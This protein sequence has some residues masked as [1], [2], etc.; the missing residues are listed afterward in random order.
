LFLWDDAFKFEAIAG[1]ANTL[2][3]R[4]SMAPNMYL[5]LDQLQFSSETD[6]I[7]IG[8]PSFSET[9]EKRRPGIWVWC[10]FFYDQAEIELPL[11]HT[12]KRRSQYHPA[13][14]IIRVVK[15]VK[16]GYPPTEKNYLSRFTQPEPW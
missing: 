8:Q 12:Q 14:P 5:Y 11:I 9:V 13:S 16:S 1:D 7:H 2:L 4:F 15:M 6:G 3:A 10:R